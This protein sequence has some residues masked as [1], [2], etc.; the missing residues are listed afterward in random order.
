MR[1][2]SIAPIAAV[3]L[4]AGPAFAQAPNVLRNKSIVVSWTENRSQRNFG[5]TAFRPVALPFVFTVYVSG[6][7]RAFK[8]ISTGSG[9]GQSGDT[10]GNARNQFGGATETQI[11]GQSIVHSSNV[12]GQGRRIQIALDAGY[13]SC[14]ATVVTAKQ[15]GQKVISSRSLVT[16]GVIEIESVSASSASCSIRDGNAF[17][18]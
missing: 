7:G 17:A 4:L 13:G 1:R 5:E 9:Q 11:R 18:R 10:V 15:S 6:E 2:A 3:L 8:R 16:G 12:G 14:S